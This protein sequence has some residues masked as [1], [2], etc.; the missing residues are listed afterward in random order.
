MEEENERILQ[1]ALEQRA[2]EEE[3]MV[4]KLKKEEKMSAVQNEVR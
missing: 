3:R 2:R 4:E 1:F